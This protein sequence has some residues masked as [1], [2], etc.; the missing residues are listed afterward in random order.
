MVPRY[1]VCGAL[2]G[3]H[4]HG[5]VQ[6]HSEQE[7]QVMTR[8]LF[9]ATAL[10]VLLWAVGSDNAYAFLLGAIGFSG[11]LLGQENFPT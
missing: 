7:N 2:A 6:Y 1:T 10:A 11:A 4:R 9:T 8:V 5:T 3:D